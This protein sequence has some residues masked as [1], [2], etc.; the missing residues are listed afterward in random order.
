MSEMIITMFSEEDPCWTAELLKLAGEDI[1]VLD[2]L[3]SEGSLEL[4]DGIY[5]L[6]EV[7]RNVYDKLKNELFLEGTPGQKP[8]DPERSV[9]RTKLRMLLDSAHLQRLSLIHI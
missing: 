7:G 4:S 1:S 6:T 8:S 3:V 2:G 5:S 9:K